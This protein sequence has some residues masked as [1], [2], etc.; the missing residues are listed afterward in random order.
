MSE[1]E[2]VK[3][4]ISL[5]DLQKRIKESMGS[6]FPHKLW[7][8][9]EISAVSEKTLGHCYIDL[10]DKD[11]STGVM[12]ARAQAIVWSSTWRVL[13][14]YFESTTHTALSAGMNVLLLV[15]VQ[16]SELYGISLIVSDIN[17][18]FTIGEIELRRL[19]IID[20]LSREGM[21]EM[22]STIP[23]PKY[24]HRFAVISSE[25]AAGYGDF[26]K[27]LHGNEYGFSFSTTL[28]SAP[29]QGSTA[30]HGIVSALDSI[31]ER[32]NDFDAVLIVRGGGSTT[33]LSCF[34]D[35]DFAVNVAQFP[36]PVMMAVGHDRDYHICDM[37]ACVSVKTPT[38]LA[39]HIV[40]IVAE[41]DEELSSIG[42]RLSLALTDKIH[43]DNFRLQEC[44]S[45]I[46]NAV[47]RRFDMEINR[48]NLLEQRVIKGNPSY[49][50]SSGYALAYKDGHKIN[51]V[52]DVRKGET[53]KV[54]LGDGSIDC[55]VTKVNNNKQ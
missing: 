45:L 30:P 4:G 27:H 34:D 36:L 14:P 10:I 55:E 38:A 21:M 43:Q 20:K 47:N 46:R 31:A 29:M 8:R 37:V 39:E 49:L 42:S 52:C 15:Q 53:I 16:F 54:L 26:I 1:S 9:G 6:S 24:P 28:F 41:I 12:N 51:S 18:S 25:S 22:N 19:Q 11:A 40:D 32:A 2:E 35:Y 48:L 13:R 23:F 7:V 3:S 44:I 33:D 50:L 17:P 5:S